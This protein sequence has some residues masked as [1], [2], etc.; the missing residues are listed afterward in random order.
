M[1]TLTKADRS[2]IMSKVRSKNTKLEMIVRRLVFGMGYRYR[3]HRT[4]LPGT[5]DLVF[6]GRRKVIFINGCFWH[7]HSDFDCR[8]SRLPKSRLDYWKPKL[9]GNRARDKENAKQLV[10]AGWDVLAVWECQT[11]NMSKLETR[12]SDFLSQT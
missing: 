2:R 4:D 1:D 9:E 5:P 11:K 7:S 8:L 3:L 6:K 10:A 12:I